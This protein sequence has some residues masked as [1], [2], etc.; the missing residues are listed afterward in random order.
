[1]QRAFSKL[2]ILAAAR[3]DSLLVACAAIVPTPML[4]AL[5]PQNGFHNAKSNSLSGICPSYFKRASSQRSLLAIT[6]TFQVAKSM[7][8]PHRLAPKSRDLSCLF[9]I[10]R[11]GG[12]NCL[13]P[14]ILHGLKVSIKYK[15]S[16]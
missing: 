5:A 11:Q 6:N 10:S 12:S 3:S 7:V 16:T 8:L 1:M 13:S 14:P 15:N 2:C 4:T 9:S